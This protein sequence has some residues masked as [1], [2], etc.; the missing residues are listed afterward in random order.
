VA[1]RRRRD[2][3]PARRVRLA[4]ALTSSTLIAEHTEPQI[5]PAEARHSMSMPA[6]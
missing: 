6:T 5:D 3:L 1:C 4:E 2:R